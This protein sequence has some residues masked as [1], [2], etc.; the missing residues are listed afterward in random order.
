ESANL[1]MADPVPVV[2]SASTTFKEVFLLSQVIYRLIK[3]TRHATNERRDLHVEFR[4]EV[5]FLRD[6][7]RR[8]LEDS[9]HGSFDQVFA[10]A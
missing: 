8:F 4:H 1:W 7:G 6:F 10:P 2:L 9:T 5:L 3:S